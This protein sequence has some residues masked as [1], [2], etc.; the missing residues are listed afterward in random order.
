MQIR[1]T[2]YIDGEWR[3]PTSTKMIDVIS[4]STETVFGRVPEGTA[5]DA[6]AAVRAARSAFAD[7]ARA[8]LAD[9]EES[10]L[11]ELM[12]THDANE[13]LASFLAKR[14]PRWE[15]R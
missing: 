13:G 14:R 5:E 9:A 10:Y 15:H 1:D 12:A 11:E 7:L 4:P 6:D 2:L 3:A 8:R